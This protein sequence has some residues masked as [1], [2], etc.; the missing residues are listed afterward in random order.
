MSRPSRWLGGALLG[1][2]VIYVAQYLFSALYDGS[3]RV[4]SVLN[5]VSAI[6]I[7]VALTVNL[8][9]C[10]GQCWLV[11][12]N[13]ALAIW[14]AHNW[15]RLLIL[16]SGESPQLHHEVIWQLIAVL[17]PLVLGTTGWRLWSGMR[18]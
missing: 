8:R 14:F 18:A 6:L 7:V 4:W 16:A 11:Y 5:V 15:I 12:A 17:I 1:Y 10:S 2:S 13:T 3:A 9:H